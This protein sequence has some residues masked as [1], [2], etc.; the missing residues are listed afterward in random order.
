L[1][2]GEGNRGWERAGQRAVRVALGIPLFLYILLVSVVV[3]LA[4]FSPFCSQPG[5]GAA[6]GS[7]GAGQGQTM[8]L[9]FLT[10]G[11][12]EICCLNTGGWTGPRLAEKPWDSPDP[13]CGVGVVLRAQV[14]IKPPLSLGPW[15]VSA[16]GVCPEQI[17]H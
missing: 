8:L 7:L 10:L 17:G 9:L 14:G 16:A 13:P 11:E 6:M 2:G 12:C 5:G 3:T 4:F 15:L 1:P